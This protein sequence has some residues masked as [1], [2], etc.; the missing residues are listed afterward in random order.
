MERL[1]IIWIDDITD[2][3]IPLS[4]RNIQ[5]KAKSLYEDL[6]SKSE[7]EVLEDFKASAGWF[8]RFKKRSNL[9]NIKITGEASSADEIAAI[10]FP[11]QL[12]DI[13]NQKGYLAEQ[14]FN[15]DETALFWK[16]CHLVASFPRKLNQ[17]QASK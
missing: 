4:T 11:K 1:L 2:K 7:I 12:A 13:V 15:V 14:I 10:S 16:K 6:R 9:H 5:E 3:R 17:C 8:N